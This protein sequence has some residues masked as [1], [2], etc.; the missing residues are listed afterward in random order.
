MKRAKIVALSLI[1]LFVVLT[2]VA[3][4]AELWPGWCKHQPKPG[5]DHNSQGYSTPEPAAIA[6]LGAG[7]VV[8]G[9]FAKRKRG[10]KQ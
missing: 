6:L 8:L 1:L 10:K 4:A 2:T 7:L 9:L 3:S 5:Q